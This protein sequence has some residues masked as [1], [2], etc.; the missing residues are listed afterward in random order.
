M[1]SKN[2]LLRLCHS[3][4]TM[5]SNFEMMPQKT[6]SLP[7]DPS[8]LATPFIGA[9]RSRGFLT[10]W[11]TIPSFSVVL[12]LRREAFPLLPVLPFVA[13]L[14][15]FLRLLLRASLGGVAWRRVASV[16]PASRQTI[17]CRLGNDTFG[18][19]YAANHA[20]LPTNQAGRAT[21]KKL[22]PISHRDF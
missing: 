7:Q 13:R 17:R 8:H 4:T 3:S 10:P 12:P 16:Q 19:V 11:P 14:G 18:A 22:E 2:I 15:F 20:A 9:H 1:E 5:C 21:E 6:H